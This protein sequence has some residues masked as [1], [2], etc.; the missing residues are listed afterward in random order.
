[1]Q[2]PCQPNRD[3]NIFISF[4]VTHDSLNYNTKCKQILIPMTSVAHVS[5][6]ICIVTDVTLLNPN[7]AHE[8]AQ[9]GLECCT[10]GYSGQS[11]PSLTPIGLL[12]SIA[13]I[14]LN[15]AQ[16]NS[17]LNLVCAFKNTL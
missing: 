6:A 17:N 3:K 11:R 2:F 8:L 13:Q 10:V 15:V 5:H 12:E 4:S 7:T 16:S 9:S 14:Q 1:M